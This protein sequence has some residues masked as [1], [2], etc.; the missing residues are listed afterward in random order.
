MTT[1][2]E[3]IEDT[4]K[5]EEMEVVEKAA[6]IDAI[7]QD[8]IGQNPYAVKSIGNGRVRAYAVVYGSEDRRDLDGQFFTKDTEGYLDI[9]RA[10]GKLPWL[11]NH[12]ADGKLKSTVFGEI[13]SMGQDDQGVWYEARILEHKLYKDYISRL[14]NAKALY[15]S[16]GALPLSVKVDKTTMAIKRWTISEV[17]STTTPADMHQVVHGYTVDEI[18]T[19]YSKLGINS[20][21]LFEQSDDVEQEVQQHDAEEAAEM[22]ATELVELERDWLNL[23]KLTL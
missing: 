21:D 1:L 15:S 20:D 16:S 2:T 10:L 9:F 7:D 3:Q 18:K 22:L 23:Q 6:T 13:D 4:E 14:I 11:Y 5:V 17:S 19:F 12:A 8:D